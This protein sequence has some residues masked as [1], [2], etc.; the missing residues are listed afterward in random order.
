MFSESRE[1]ISKTSS[2][3]NFLF[4]L[5]SN[6]KFKEIISSENPLLDLYKIALFLKH[7]L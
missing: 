3:F 2:T 5:F 7:L 6:S 4:K 1:D